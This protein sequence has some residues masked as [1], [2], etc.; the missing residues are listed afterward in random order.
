[1][2][3]TKAPD[4]LDYS[5]DAELGVDVMHAAF[6]GP[7]FERHAHATFAIG[8]TLRGLQSFNHRGRRH[9]STP[10]RI[11]A[12]NPEDPHDGEAGDA[13]GF[14]Y[15]MM[16]PDTGVWERALEDATGRADPPF[17]ADTLLDDPALAR[18]FAAAMPALQ[19]RATSSAGLRESLA[20]ESRFDL[21]LL[22]LALRHGRARLPADRHRDSDAAAVR[23]IREILHA[24]FD[25]DIRLDDLARAA[26]RSRFQVTRAFQATTGLP[27]HRYLTNIRLEHARARLAAGDAPADV[28]AAVG[29]AD[30]SHLS[31]RF[32]AAYGVTPGRFQAAY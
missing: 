15:W 12:F 26:G 28:A 31:R 6:S 32:K 24:E 21:L 23:R 5:R 7:A 1:M 8:V 17:F 16:Y 14:S 4:F 25:R 19:A 30:Q 18:V 22:A 2:T 27:P 11:I 3:L 10:G 29:F 13:A 20:A 9:T